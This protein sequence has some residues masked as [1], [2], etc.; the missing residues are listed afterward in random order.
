MPRRSRFRRRLLLLLVFVGIIWLGLWG[1]ASTLLPRTLSGLIP[2]LVTQAEQLGIG[3]S[4][5]N[6]STPHVSPW[7]NRVR[8]TDATARFDLDKNDAIHL[9]STVEMKS[10]E[11]S[12]HNPFTLRGGV[13]AKGLEVRLDSSDL[14]PSLPFESFWTLRA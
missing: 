2:R 12:V 14:P 9:Q 10:V 7:L 3:L 1:A 8:L 13:S 4:E 5:I 6:F 11:V